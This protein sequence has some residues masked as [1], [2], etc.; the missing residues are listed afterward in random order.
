MD[1]YWRWIRPKS[2]CL[3]A[4]TSASATKSATAPNFGEYSACRVANVTAADCWSRGDTTLGRHLCG[5]SIGPIQDALFAYS[6]SKADGWFFA[7][8]QGSGGYAAAIKPFTE[9]KSE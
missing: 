7:S 9:F 2:V 6:L 8:A 1:E 5:R 3:K 4:V